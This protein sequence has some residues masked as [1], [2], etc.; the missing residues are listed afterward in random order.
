VKVWQRLKN[1]EKEEQRFDDNKRWSF[2]HTTSNRHTS[3]QATVEG[4]TSKRADNAAHDE[5]VLNFGVVLQVVHLEKRGEKI[6]SGS[7]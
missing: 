2:K 5:E 7:H 3:K 6:L 1:T 4:R